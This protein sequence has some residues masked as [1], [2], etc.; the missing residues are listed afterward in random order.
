MN[1]L[2]G[3]WETTSTFD[4][5]KG[6]ISVR[7]A[8]EAISAFDLSTTDVVSTI[9]EVKNGLKDEYKGVGLEKIKSLTDNELVVD[10]EGTVFTLHRV[11]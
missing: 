9:Q 8:D 11:K 1:K 5:D 3:T 6:D 2:N 7:I 10:E 4:F